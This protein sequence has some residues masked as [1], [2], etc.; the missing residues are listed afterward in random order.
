LPH[1]QYTTVTP[2]VSYILQM[3]VSSVR[4]F[5]QSGF[6]SSMPGWSTHASLQR[7]SAIVSHNN[8]RQDTPF[9]IFAQLR[10]FAY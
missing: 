6:T 9:I 2:L 7:S 10:R 4:H 1:R 3:L 8:S 5:T